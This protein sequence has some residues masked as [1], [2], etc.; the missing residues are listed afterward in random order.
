MPNSQDIVNDSLFSNHNEEQSEYENE[1]SILT[2]EYSDNNIVAEVSLDPSQMLKDIRRKHC[3]RLIIAQL[4]INSLRTKFESLSFMIKDNIDILLTSETKIDTLFP[5]AQFHIEG[6]TIYRCDRD[7]NGGG[8]L[9]YVR[10][11]IPSTLLNIDCS[12]E[13]FYVE[14]IIRKKKWLIYSSYN[15]NRNLISNHLREI[16]KKI[17]LNSSKYDNFIL[18]GILILSQVSNP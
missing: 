6:F 16:G 14:S 11:D 1:T 15:S 7:A 9:L 5:T 18:L 17:Y 3:N 13:R 12:I 8:L 10:E 4:N 2:S